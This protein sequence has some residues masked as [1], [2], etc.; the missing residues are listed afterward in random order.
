MSKL[1][2]KDLYPAFNVSLGK[3]LAAAA[4]VD[5]DLNENE[6][7]C[8]KAIVLQLPH[9]NFEDWRKLKIY[10]AYPISPPEQ[11][12][13][14]N[15]FLEKVFHKG[16]SKLA[17]EALVKII[18][19]DGEV[20][21]EEQKFTKELESDLANN[22]GSFLKKLKFFLFKNSIHQQKSWDPSKGGREKFIHEFFDNP[23]YFLF[24][25]AVLKEQLELPHS[26]PELQKICLYAA[27]LC[28]FA[29]ED[30]HLDLIER[31]FI[32]NTLK[33]HSMLSD[34]VAHCILKIANNLNVS[35]LQLSQ[36]CFSMADATIQEERNK[37]F[38]TLSKLILLDRE[39]STKECEYLRTAALY[40]EINEKLWVQ[41]MGNIHLKTTFSV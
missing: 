26:K 14:I 3:T 4:W 17:I 39:M 9:I 32:I 15:D 34:S 33:E 18:K 22:V 23:I 6:M 31:E 28:W 25:K 11:K 37:I 19:A 2:H 16:H 24:R 5:G 38:V 30:D 7:D 1:K 8:L 36:L 29:K 20:T 10:L 35:E 13:I 27:V 40:L 41:I 21:K 12:S